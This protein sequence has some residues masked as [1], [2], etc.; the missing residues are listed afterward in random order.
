MGGWR[1]C[2]H[3]HPLKYSES[4]AHDEG[5]LF[6]AV[7]FVVDNDLAQSPSQRTLLN[8]YTQK[9]MTQS[10][11]VL[12]KI[13]IAEYLEDVAIDSAEVDADALILAQAFSIGGNEAVALKLYVAA[14]LQSPDVLFY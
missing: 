11:V 2:R 5:G 3:S 14:L 4:I 1:K 10:Y 8:A 13:C 9:W 12:Y 7:S 6:D